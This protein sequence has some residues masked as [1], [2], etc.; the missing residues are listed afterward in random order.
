MSIKIYSMSEMLVSLLIWAIWNE[1]FDHLRQ[2]RGAT[3]FFLSF[4]TKHKQ[5]FQPE[6]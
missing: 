2:L 5:Q 1:A 3:F 6:G 4:K